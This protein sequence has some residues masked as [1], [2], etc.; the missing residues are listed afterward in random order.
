MTLVANCWHCGEAFWLAELPDPACKPCQFGD[1]IRTT[2]Q[3]L[4]NPPKVAW[5]ADNAVARYFSR[6]G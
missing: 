1:G 2:E 6:R 3:L 4:T 5:P